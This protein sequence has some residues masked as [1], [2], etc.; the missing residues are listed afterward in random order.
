V[1]TVKPQDVMVPEIGIMTAT[2]GKAE[3]EMV[4]ALLVRYH[5]AKGLTE[6]TPITRRELADFLAADDMA[7]GWAKDPFWRPAPW[8]LVER[9]FI[10][11]WSNADDPGTVTP[12]FL[13][14]IAKNGLWIRNSE[15]RQ[16]RTAEAEDG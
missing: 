8:L 9:G 5:H 2:L 14:A 7:K 10:V 6:W 12:K 1:S 4:A 16:P 13:E 3:A 11:G 15:L